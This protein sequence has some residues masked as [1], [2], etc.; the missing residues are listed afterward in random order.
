MAKKTWM[1]LFLVGM[2]LVA[3]SS[4][5]FAQS[6]SADVVF[7]SDKEVTT[8]KMY[9]AAQKMRMDMQ[10]MITITRLDKKLVWMI[11]PEEKMYM[12]MPIRPGNYVPSAEAM[13]GEVERVL[14]GSDTVDGKAASKY[15]VTVSTEGK[16]DSFYQWMATDSG[17]PV[18]M[19]ALDDSWS[20]E[21][22]NLV[23]GEPAAALFE[24]PAG[25]TKMSMPGM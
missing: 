4:V 23:I 1:I 8:G 21:Y 20:Q 9:A 22:R 11:M 3:G 14:I 17:F 16:K 12:E 25:Y 24:P 5:V 10:G 15:R 13:E 7:K 18:K 6:F 2:L 19:A